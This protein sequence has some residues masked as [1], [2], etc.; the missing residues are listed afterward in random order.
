M[1]NRFFETL[2]IL[3]MLTVHDGVKYACNQCDF[4]ATRQ[5]NLTTHIQSIHEGIKYACNQCNYQ[6]STQSNL[7]AHT[8]RKHL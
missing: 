2:V 8:K 7:T 1:L 6:A 4:Q 5:D 3:L